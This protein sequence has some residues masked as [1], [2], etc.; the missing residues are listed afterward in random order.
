MTIE[1][2]IENLENDQRRNYTEKEGNLYK[3]QSLSIE[4]LKLV[5]Y[6]RQ[7]GVPSSKDALPGETEK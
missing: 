3:A 1:E 4:A 7:T 5:T 6:L 2:A